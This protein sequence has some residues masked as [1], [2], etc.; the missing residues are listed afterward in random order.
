MHGDFQPLQCMANSKLGCDDLPVHLAMISSSCRR[1]PLSK[2]RL[3]LSFAPQHPKF[4]HQDRAISA[5]LDNTTAVIYAKD[6]EGRYQL[7][8]RRFEQLFDITMQEVKGK[9]DFDV[10]PT[11]QATKFHQNDI[12]VL[13]K[14][15]AIE[16]EEV[17]PHDDGL[18]T[19]I[20]LKFPIRSDCGSVI[21]VCGISTD[22]TERRKLEDEITRISTREKNWISRELHDSVGQQLTGLAYLAKSLVKRHSDDHERSKLQ[23]TLLC[24]IQAALT[25]TRRIVKGMSPVEFDS[26]GLRLALDELAN[27][28]RTTFQIECDFSSDPQTRV[29][30]NELA[31]QWY[32][33]AQ[34]ATNNAIRHGAPS[35]LAIS[36]NS[37]ENDIVMRIQDN[38]CGFRGHGTRG[39]GLRIMRHRSNLVAADLDISSSPTGTTVTCRAKRTWTKE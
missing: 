36:L 34:E 8:N 13:K 11:E 32:R 10:F 23:E 6:T 2:S 24:G 1:D 19:Y 17:A 9:T 33:I 37:D 28:I 30:D 22:I 26:F 7:I 38:G 39:M 14:N 31:L 3:L 15:G 5:I 18:H 16:F 29:Y 25:E 12:A 21:G 20:S 35:R 27:H 4:F